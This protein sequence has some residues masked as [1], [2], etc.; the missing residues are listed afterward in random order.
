MKFPRERLIAVIITLIMLVLMF[1]VTAVASFSADDTPSVSAR[2]ATLYEPTTKSFIYTKN[3]DERLPFASTTKIMT[4][5]IAIEHGELD[6]QITVADGACGIEGSS[7]YLKAGE[8]MTM[9]DL[10]TALMLRSANDA[11]AAIAYAISGG[12]EEFA[13]LMNERALKLGLENTHF[14]NPHGLDAEGH[15]TTARELALIASEAMRLPEFRNI[16]ATYKATVTNTDG[17]VRL[18]VNHNKLLRL[19]EGATGIKTGFTKKSGRCLVG[20]AER[21]GLT[22]ISV[23]IDAPDDWNDHE[24]LFDLGFASYEYKELAE[25][26]QFSFTIPVIDA[27]GKTLTAS[28]K[29]SL[30]VV[31]KRGEGEIT[32][33]TELPRY[34]TSSVRE[35]DELGRVVFKQNGKILGEISITADVNAPSEEQ[36]RFFDFF[37][38]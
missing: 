15:Y 38:K 23:T 28:N 6:R 31:L 24:K 21:D 29:Q 13:D 30:G 4:A 19:Y 33:E 35:G 16:A 36:R 18:V 2:S 14:M 17:D 27:E 10:V 26:S 7:L 22:L 3:A 25:A 9:R 20:A 11:A 32:S 37:K 5:L 12:I 34:I 1:I 8:V